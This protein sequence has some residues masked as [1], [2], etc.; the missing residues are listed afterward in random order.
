MT[1][2]PGELFA[3]GSDEVQADAYATLVKLAKLI[4]LYGNRQVLI[5]GHTDAD[6]D[7]AYHKELSERRAIK[8]RDYVAKHAARAA[9]AHVGQRCD[10]LLSYLHKARPGSLFLAAIEYLH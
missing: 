4:G 8:Q 1:T 10:T 2:V 3:V 6:G 9:G 5:I 7:D